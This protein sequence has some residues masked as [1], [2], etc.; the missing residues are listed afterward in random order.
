MLFG[1]LFCCC[2]HRWCLPSSKSRHGDD[3]HNVNFFFLWFKLILL[4]DD[5][6][7]IRK[8]GNRFIE[9]TLNTTSELSFICRPKRRKKKS[10]CCSRTS[11][12]IQ[13]I[14][15]ECLVV[16]W[17]R[18]TCMTS[19]AD[20]RGSVS[21][22]CAADDECET[23]GEN[24]DWVME[25]VDS[26]VIIHLLLLCWPASVQQKHFSPKWEPIS[27]T[28]ST[29]IRFSAIYMTHELDDETGIFVRLPRSNWTWETQHN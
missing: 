1:S 15:I 2:F 4:S 9:R 28:Q 21:G 18:L 20:R 27:T 14:R 5:M 25:Y 29:K 8:H 22:E 24:K 10:C 12:A 3:R 13:W 7:R 26:N 11:P 19:L 6:A 17:K 16:R 23:P